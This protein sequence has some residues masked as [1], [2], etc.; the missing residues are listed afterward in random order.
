MTI[1]QAE[2]AILV[3]IDLVKKC[4]EDNYKIIVTGE[5]GIGNT[6]T[7]SAIA[8]VLLD[9]SV[10][11]V[12]GKGAGL[13]N[14]GFEKKI[15]AIKKAIQINAPNKENPIELISKLGGYDI[16]AMVEYTW[17]VQSIAFLLS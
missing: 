16:A 17:V 10:E 14:E 5:M 2:K 15:N 1:N 12:T 13:N 6:T 3:G 11:S 7:S 4:K 8:S 9:L